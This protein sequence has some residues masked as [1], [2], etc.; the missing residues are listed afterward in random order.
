[1]DWLRKHGSAITGLFL[2][3][4]YIYLQLLEWKRH[5]DD[6]MLTAVSVIVTVILWTVLIVEI[7]SYR[8]RGSGE[9]AN[10]RIPSSLWVRFLTSYPEIAG[11]PQPGKGPAK[12]PQKIRAEFLNCEEVSYRVKVISWERGRSNGVDAG[13]WRG[14]LQLRIANT[15]YPEWNGVEE[16]HV[17]P[18]EAFRIWLY[19]NVT[20]SDDQF[21]DRI[22]SGNLG[23]IHFLINGKEIAV[24]IE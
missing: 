16:L 4:L 20:L 10:R 23:T 11:P 15:W 2:S 8:R 22:N 18:G 7:V 3:G 6:L 1:M 13:F 14:C 5:G 17:P 19:P 24:P 9:G 12:K 21:K